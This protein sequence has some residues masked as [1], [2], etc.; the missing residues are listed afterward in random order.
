MKGGGRV[1]E[2]KVK[3][4]VDSGAGVDGVQR[5][6]SRGGGDLEV[7]GIDTKRGGNYHSTGIV[8]VVWK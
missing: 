7:G 1:I 4:G 2:G 3:V 6:S 5:Q 8:E